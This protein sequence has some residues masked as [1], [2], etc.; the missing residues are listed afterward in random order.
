MRK[1]LTGKEKKRRG[2]GLDMLQ[3]LGQKEG[4]KEEMQQ[5]KAGKKKEET[6]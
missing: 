2:T 6:V 5:R 1:V 4:G 3:R